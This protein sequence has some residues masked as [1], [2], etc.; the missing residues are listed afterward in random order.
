M[1]SSSPQPTP[2]DQDLAALDSP[3]IESLLREQGALPPPP[4]PHSSYS[5]TPSKRNSWRGRHDINGTVLRE[6]DVGSG[7]VESE[8]ET[9]LG[10]RICSRMSLQTQH[11]STRQTTR[12]SQVSTSSCRF[13]RR[14]VVSST[15]RRE[16]RLA[17]CLTPLF[18]LG[19]LVTTF[20]VVSVVFIRFSD[21]VVF[22][23]DVA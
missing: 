16:G 12:H 8:R 19:I 10:V 23:T 17:R 6:G 13:R 22:D 7:R 4:P 21:A 15:S 3:S 18:S 14:R 20:F 1:Q 2:A 11:C 9:N 5:D